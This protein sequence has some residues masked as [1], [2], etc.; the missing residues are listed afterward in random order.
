MWLKTV[1]TCHLKFWP[2]IILFLLFIHSCF[3]GHPVYHITYVLP[4]MQPDRVK[5]Q[6]DAHP[7]PLAYQ[8]FSAVVKKQE[9]D[10]SLLNEQQCLILNK[11]LSGESLFII[12]MG[13]W[14]LILCM[15]SSET[16]SGCG[17]LYLLQV[18]IDS[19]QQKFGDAFMVA[20]MATIGMAAS[21][22]NGILPFCIHITKAKFHPSL[23]QTIYSWAGLTESE[24]TIVDVLKQISPACSP[25]WDGMRPRFLYGMKVC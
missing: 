19:L 4:N 12:G 18:I 9:I 1:A 5:L 25:S 20:V 8:F 14:F 13:G 3:I 16:L 21:R 22:I 2:T 23:G 11:V 15:C 24:V 17:K 10:V 7:Q 6:Q